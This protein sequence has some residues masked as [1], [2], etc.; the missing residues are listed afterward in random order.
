MIGSQL[1]A[2]ADTMN[3]FTAGHFAF[4]P[5]S[6]LGGYPQAVRIFGDGDHLETLIESLNAA[7]FGADEGEAPPGDTQRPNAH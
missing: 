2:N 1:R 4:H 6:Q 3:E 7:V 5:F